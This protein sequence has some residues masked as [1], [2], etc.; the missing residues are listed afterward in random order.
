MDLYDDVF[1][2]ESSL[3]KSQSGYKFRE[4]QFEMAMLIDEALDEK[5]HAVIEAGTGT[6]KSFA[7]LAPIVMHL[8]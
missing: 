3:A 7:Y 1:S 2:P 4:S 8:M 5:K 6:G